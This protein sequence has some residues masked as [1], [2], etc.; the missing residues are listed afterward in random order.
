MAKK[1]EL[2]DEERAELEAREPLV[3]LKRSVE[4]ARAEAVSQPYTKAGWAPWLAA[5]EELEVAV[6]EHADRYGVSRLVVHEYVSSR[7]LHPELHAGSEA[8]E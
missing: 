4:A 7:V 5:A 6:T 1:K 3:E 8:A 2:G